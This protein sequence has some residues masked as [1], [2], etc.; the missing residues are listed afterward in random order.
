MAVCEDINSLF[1]VDINNAIKDFIKEVLVSAMDV[2]EDVITLV[3]PELKI[4]RNLQINRNFEL[5]NRLF[6]IGAATGKF[7]GILQS[8]CSGIRC[9][10]LLIK[11]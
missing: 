4:L 11:G 2:S 7:R 10:Q 6:I 1:P 5:Y 8:L 9:G 3:A